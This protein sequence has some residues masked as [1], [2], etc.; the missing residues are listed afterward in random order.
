MLCS[1]PFN[2]HLLTNLFLSLSLYT[3]VGILVPFKS[4]DVQTL[5]LNVLLFLF[6]AFLLVFRLLYLTFVQIVSELRNLSSVAGFV[7]ASFCFALGCM[8]GSAFY[9]A[10]GWITSF[11]FCSY[12]YLGSLANTPRFAMSSTPKGPILVLF[13]F[14]LFLLPLIFFYSAQIG[15]WFH[16]PWVLAVDVSIY[17]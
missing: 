11:A 14:N 13:F 10:F 16:W 17:K 2:F 3:L 4:W 7:P 9:F 15:P 1:R 8:L 5:F 12:S 6:K